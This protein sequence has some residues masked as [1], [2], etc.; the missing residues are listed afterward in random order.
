MLWRHWHFAHESSSSV[1]WLPLRYGNFGSV[2]LDS[3]LDQTPSPVDQHQPLVFLDLIN[4]QYLIFSLPAVVFNCYYLLCLTRYQIRG[5]WL[6]SLSL[7]AYIIIKNLLICF[8][9]FWSTFAPSHHC[10]PV[11]CFRSMFSMIL[12]LQ[13]YKCRAPRWRRPAPWYESDSTNMIYK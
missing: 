10:R 9:M 2:F 4:H 7:V 8:D 1:W 12:H 13:M 6:E 3:Q 11:S 5:G